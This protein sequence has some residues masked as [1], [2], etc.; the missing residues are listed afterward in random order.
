MGRKL[1]PDPHTEREG[2]PG[3]VSPTSVAH[4]MA[5]ARQQQHFKLPAPVP[6]EITR[7]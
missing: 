6:L 3:L 2:S 7:H 4:F 1:D 5:G